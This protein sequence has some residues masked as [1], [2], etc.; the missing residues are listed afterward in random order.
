MNYISIFKEMVAL[1][2]QSN[3]DN[4]LEMYK[5]DI[6]IHIPRNCAKSFDFHKAEELIEKGR[7]EARKTIALYEENGTL[8]QMKRNQAQ[9]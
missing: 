5:P 9:A 2:L 8:H 4:A 6:T 1:V 7:T 3:V